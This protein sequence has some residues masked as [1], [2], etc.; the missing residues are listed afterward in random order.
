MYPVKKCSHCKENIVKKKTSKM[1]VIGNT[2]IAIPSPMHPIVPY[3]VILL[4][5][6]D[7]NRI[8]LKTMKEYELGQEYVEE[9]A[10][11]PAAVSI[12]KVKYDIYD[13]VEHA[14]EL[15]NFEAEEI[16]KVL[17]KPQIIAPAYPYQAVNTNPKTVDAIIKF[18]FKK[19]VKPENITVAEQS[20]YGIDT[21]AAAAKAGILGVCKKNDVKFLDLRKGQFEEKKIENHSFK[22]SKEIL[23]KDIVINAPILKTHSQYGIAGAIQNMASVVSVET[24]KDM[25]KK[26]VDEQL[27]YLNK[28]LKYITLGDATTGMQGQGPLMTG[29]PAF[30]NLVLASRDPV[31]LDKVFSEIGFFKTPDYV[32][33]ASRLNLGKEN[34]K[35]IEIVGTELDAVKYPLKAANTNPSPHSTV[36]VIDGRAWIGDYIAMH[37]TLSKLASIKTSGINI[38]IGKILEKNLLDNKEKIVAFGDDSIERLN[39]LEVKTIAQIK[40]SPPDPVES[41][42]LLKKLL[43]SNGQ[44][45]IN[46]L[47]KVKSKIVSAVK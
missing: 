15:I 29:E 17:I 30:L 13:A 45:K 9:K 41:F 33:V 32:N 24:Q 47:D 18:L 46:L 6:E 28:L 38:V 27:A 44:S 14:L 21:E 43:E 36:N 23:N 1:R 11:D 20:A 42:V 35:E 4:E 3:N 12:V 2:K 5:D 10:K 37:N 25:H 34:L 7:G 39:E 8:P 19:K 16:S 40:G 22:I 26:N 31:A